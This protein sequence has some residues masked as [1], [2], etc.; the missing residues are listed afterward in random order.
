MNY[1]IGPLDIDASQD[2]AS[3]RRQLIALNAE[4]AE[5][6]LQ[7]QSKVHFVL[8]VA[9]VAVIGV[10]AS[11]LADALHLDPGAIVRV[12]VPIALSSVVLAAVVLASAVFLQMRAAEQERIDTRRL[13]EL[14]DRLA[15][16]QP[17]E[18]A[19]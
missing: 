17:G 2:A 15:R 5:H 11:W 10:V 1:T 8:L 19:M 9:L 13:L 7:T 4:Y 12:G 6:R 16:S 3:L 14:Q 18:T